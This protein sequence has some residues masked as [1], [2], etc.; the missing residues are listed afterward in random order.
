MAKSELDTTLQEITAIV[1]RD[2]RIDFSHYK[3]ST[4]GRAHRAAAVIAGCDNLDGYIQLLEDSSEERAALRNDL[5][6][7]V[8]GFFRDPEAWVYLE[9]QIIPRLVAETKESDE[10]RIWVTAC[11][12]GEEAYSLAMLVQEGLETAGKSRD[13]KIFAT[14]I[15]DAALA[16][17][18]S[19]IYSASVMEDISPQRVARFFKKKGQSYQVVRRLREMMIFAQQNLARDPPFTRMHLV[20]CRNLLIYMQPQLQHQVL[21]TLHFALQAKGVLFLGAAESVG[22]LD[23][24]FSSL[25]QKWKVFEKRRDVKLPMRSGEGLL[26]RALHTPRIANDTGDAGRLATAGI[27]GQRSVRRVSA[28]TECVLSAGHARA[29]VAAS[30]RRFAEVPQHSRRQ[31]ADGRD[32][33]GAPAAVTAAAARPCV[34][35]TEKKPVAYSGMKVDQDNNARSVDMHVTYHAGGNAWPEFLMILFKEPDRP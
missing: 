13:V 5:L 31:G 15:D 20:T 2:Q 32:Q 17:A 19:G 29:R 27:H 11:S 16:K 26:V 21:S 22:E 8:T 30:L 18:G 1:A 24:E 34:G 25:H 7:N 28:R 23:P 9:Q 33:A 4:L 35:R 3:P 14:D 6:I 10:L 12:S